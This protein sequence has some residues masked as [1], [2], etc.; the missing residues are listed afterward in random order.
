MDQPRIADTW[1]RG[2]PYERYIGRWSRQVAP[3]FLSWLG[4]RAGLAWLDVGCG[5][6]AA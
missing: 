3:E 5:T 1:E 4:L 2:N 6:G